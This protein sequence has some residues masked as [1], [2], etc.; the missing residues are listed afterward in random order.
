[1]RTPQTTSRRTISR[2]RRMAATV[3]VGGALLAG[4]ITTATSASAATGDPGILGRIKACE[5]GGSY[6][7]QNPTS[8]ASGAYQF[9][10]NTWR[11]LPA[12]AGYSTAAAAPAAVQDQAARQLFAQQGTSPWLASASCWSGGGSVPATATV[13][14]SSPTRS[15]TTT[16]SGSRSYRY[17]STATSSSA[18]G[19][20]EHED[21][22]EAAAPARSVARWTGHAGDAQYGSSVRRHEANDERSAN[23]EHRS[24]GERSHTE[25]SSS[26]NH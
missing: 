17:G 23:T 24:Y 13:T 10:T 16:A 22:Y 9:L 26:E 20:A 15:S 8:S 21:P 12:S 3:A 11:S 6:T 4:G 19:G 5:S 1:M 25:G 2:T 18:R 14:R 7:A